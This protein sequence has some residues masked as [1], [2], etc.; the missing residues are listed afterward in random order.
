MTKHDILFQSAGREWARFSRE[1]RD[2]WNAVAREKAL[3]RIGEIQTELHD[4]KVKRVAAGKK[5]EAVDDATAGLVRLSKCALS[6][7]ALAF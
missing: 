2:S 7:E 6:D 5:H 4:L 1:Q 3:R